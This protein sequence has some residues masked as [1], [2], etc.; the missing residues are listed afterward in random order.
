MVSRDLGSGFSAVPQDAVTLNGMALP[1]L[2]TMTE[3]YSGYWHVIAPNGRAV[4]NENGR[5]YLYLTFEDA[6][7]NAKKLAELGEYSTCG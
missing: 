4:D 1:Q 6:A 2:N 5:P 7:D 3:P